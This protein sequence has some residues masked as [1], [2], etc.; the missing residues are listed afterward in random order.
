V[1]DQVKRDAGARERVHHGEHLAAG[2]AERVAR[3]GGVET[4]GYVIGDGRHGIAP[5]VEWA[6]R[7]LYRA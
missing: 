1:L 7:P 2:D 3:A 6:A 4:L 5:E